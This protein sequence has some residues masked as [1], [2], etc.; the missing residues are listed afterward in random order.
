LRLSKGSG[1]QKFTP[2]VTKEI[3]QTIAQGSEKATA[4]LEKCLDAMIFPLP[5]SLGYPTD[6]AQ[7]GYYPG[8]IAI[9][10][11]LADIGEVLAND[12]GIRQENTRVKKT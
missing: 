9:T 4:L 8:D 11:E 6:V 3:L 10:K 1:D 5:G 12:Y 7:S 2:N